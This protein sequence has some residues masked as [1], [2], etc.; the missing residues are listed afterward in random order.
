M[1]VLLL[2]G[3]GLLGH[4]VLRQL[5]DRGHSVHALVRNVQSLHIQHP[6]ITHFEGSFLNPDTLRQAAQGCN[7][8][9]NCTGTTD[10]SL[11]HLDDYLPVNKEGC[12]RVAEVMEQLHIDTLVQVSTANTIGYGSPTLTADETLPWQPPFSQSYYAQS[13]KA[14]EEITLRL[15]QRHPD[16]HIIVVNPGFMLGAYDYKPSSG[17]LLQ[18]AYRL[19]L[20]LA[21]RGGKSFV[22]VKDAAAAI[23]NA[24]TQ[25][26]H[27]E[28]YLLTGE[29]LTLRQFY[30]LQA[31]TC[32]YRQC[33]LPVPNTLLLIVGRLGDLLRALGLRT[34]VSTKNVRQLMVREYYTNLKARQHLSMP[35]TP[36]AQSIQD[37]FRSK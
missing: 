31:T 18:A 32:G 4:N 17:Q 13:K 3:N 26:T 33:I 29:N 24:L 11:P 19:P 6:D 36:V 16:W 7:A 34:Q 23:V 25:G 28:K 5:L 22:P 20:M 8:I 10:M 9:I 37:Y 1:T 30:R 2:G 21:P 12:Q 35:T 27:G 14:G 15:A